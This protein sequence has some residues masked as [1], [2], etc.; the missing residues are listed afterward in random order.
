MNKISKKQ[1]DIL[2]AASESTPIDGETLAFEL[3]RELEEI[4]ADIGALRE[5]KYIQEI[6]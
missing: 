1:F 5:I 2:L 3:H 4:E 6:E